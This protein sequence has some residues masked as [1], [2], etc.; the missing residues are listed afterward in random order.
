MN[1]TLMVCDAYMR[2][3]PIAAARLLEQMPPEDLAVLFDSADAAS[4]APAFEHMT[5]ERAAD[6][7]GTLGAPL[8]ARL[9]SKTH[10][11]FQVA[12]LRLLKPAA[13]S[14]LLAEL[15]PEVAKP[16][17]QM[18]RYPPGTAGG[19]M[20]P[21]VFTVPDD[22]TVKEALERARVASLEMP[23]YVYVLDRTQTLVGVVSLKKLI[24]ARRGEP[25]STVM[26]RDIVSLS[27]MAPQAEI[28]KTPHWREFHTLPVT[29]ED[30]LFL[31]VV[32]YETVA[33][34]REELSD[35]KNDEGMLD[36]ALALGEL[37]WMGLSGIMDGISG[38]GSE[39]AARRATNERE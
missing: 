32:R 38:R 17:E 12:A 27:A 5:V 7:L 37:Y 36:T 22:I 8:G 21:F 6:C 25:V 9:L 39:P 14:T 4:A 33:R 28:V 1:A 23:F 29:D 26:R 24:R 34:L 19:L 10:P 3:H 18:L 11:D 16:L 13:C 35:A 20:D 15:E 31:G 2:N 30:N